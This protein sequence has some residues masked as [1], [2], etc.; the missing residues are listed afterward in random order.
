M[1]YFELCNILAQPHN[2][3][4]TRELVRN[5]LKNFNDIPQLNAEELA[6]RC[7]VSPS[8]L[9]K[10]IRSLNFGN[11]T[12][13]RLR[14]KRI[15]EGDEG[16]FTYT[17]I[18]DESYSE[19]VTETLSRELSLM[20]QADIDSMADAAAKAVLSAKR[21]FILSN[22][23]SYPQLQVMA[24][25]LSIKKD[26][27][28][29]VLPKTY[30]DVAEKIDS[31]TVTVFIR[32]TNRSVHYSPHQM[33]DAAERGAKTIFVSN[34]L[35]SMDTEI[36]DYSIVYDGSSKY[37]FVSVDILMEMLKSAIAK[38]IPELNDSFL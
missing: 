9:R 1:P 33:K 28:V 35:S 2:D 21:L 26:C 11:Y 37:P 32:A 23:V 22:S 27:D 36:A 4:F 19:S 8:A 6:D 12:E 10:F 18:K 25:M 16:H 30:W 38:N 3:D 31:E 24:M 15:F 13:F 29:I 34:F 7:F 14:A 20:R 5:L 17:D